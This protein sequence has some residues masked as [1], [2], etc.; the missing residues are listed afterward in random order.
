MLKINWQI[1]SD[2]D[3]NDPIAV[4]NFLMDIKMV[5]EEIILKAQQ[6]QMEVRSGAPSSSDIE[7]GEAIP[8]VE[9]ATYKIY[10][11]ING[12]VKSITYS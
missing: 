5:L 7:E 1:P 10:R 6:T 9:G 12:N 11:K 4:H 8:S 3:I 2:V